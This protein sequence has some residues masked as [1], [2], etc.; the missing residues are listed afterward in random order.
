MPKLTLK[1]VTAK[2]FDQIVRLSNTLTTEQQKC[3]APNIA[4]LAQAYVNQK[5]AWPR[6]IYLGNQPI[7]FI[8]LALWDDDIPKDDWPA[9]Y[10]WRFMIAK[11]YQKQGIGTRILD[12]IKQKCIKD[13]IKTFYTSCDMTYDE[14]YRFYINYGFIDTGITDDDEQVLKMYISD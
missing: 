7:G 5:R 10:L 8:M 3:V 1:K 2:N 14:P 13:G 9:Y 12:M 11:D 4:S 6:A